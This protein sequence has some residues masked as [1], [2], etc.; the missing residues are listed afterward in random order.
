MRAVSMQKPVTVKH[1]NQ[2]GDDF[3]RQMLELKKELNRI[4][5]NFNQAVHKL[6]LLDKIPEFRIWLQ[7]YDGVQKLLTHKIDKIE[8]RMLQLYEKLLEK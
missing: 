4:G 8:L 5:N 6:H 1:H 7:Q 3:L 2:S